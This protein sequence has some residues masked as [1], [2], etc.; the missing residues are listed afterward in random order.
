LR[1]EAVV[2][3]S[4]T[5]DSELMKLVRAIVDGDA[6]AVARLLAVSPDLARACFKTGASRATAQPYFLTKI[7]RY[8]Y[9]GDTSLHIAAAGY[10]TDFV[11]RLIS[12]GADVRATNRRGAEPLHAAAAGTPGSPTWHPHAQARTIA[13]LIAAGADP[14][15]PDQGGATP[16]HKAVRTRCAAAVKALIDG[17][18]SSTQEQERL[19]GAASR[20][21]QFRPWRQRVAGGKGGAAG[22]SAPARSAWR[23]ASLALQSPSGAM[24]PRW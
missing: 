23:N 14:N 12:A 9:A 20:A 24:V 6:D 17:C 19:D 7:G 13:R 18:R 3:V 16:L 4:Q 5:S 2:I 21:S 11:E 1:E 10:R 8:I 22:D 15:A